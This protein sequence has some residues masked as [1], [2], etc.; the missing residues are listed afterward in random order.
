MKGQL[1]FIKSFFWRIE[2]LSCLWKSILVENLT[3][4]NDT[5]GMKVKLKINLCINFHWFSFF[6]QT[7]N[8]LRM[9]HCAWQWGNW[10][11]VLW[12][13]KE[14]CFF[15]RKNWLLFFCFPHTRE[16]SKNKRH[17]KKFKWLSMIAT[18]FKLYSWSHKNKKQEKLFYFVGFTS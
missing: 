7:F 13:L 4:K 14:N 10:N 1:F 12:K 2:A 6:C 17:K 8:S 16:K 18:N 11:F 5:C 3:E 9:I 15:V